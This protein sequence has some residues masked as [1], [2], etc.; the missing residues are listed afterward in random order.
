MRRTKREKA[1]ELT[2]SLADTPLGGIILSFTPKGLAALDFAEEPGELDPGCSSLS[3]P[4]D[5][6]IGR[7]VKE[8]RAFLAGAPAD[9]HN[10]PLD[11][12]GTPFQ[13]R[14]WQELRRIPWGGAISYRELA[15]RAGSPQ[16]FRAVGQANA[17]NPIPIIIP[18][19]R[20]ISADGGLGGYSSGLWRK[21]WLLDH[22]GA[23]Y[24]RS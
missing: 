20:V 7:V 22:E 3:D 6:R 14:V 9:F 17:V 5:P 13:L 23:K 4:V 15:R 1:R 19:H 16:A 21:R 2:I 18:C 8:L 24:K 12:Q 10:L 11:L